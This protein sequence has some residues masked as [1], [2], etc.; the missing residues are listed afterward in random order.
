MDDPM[1]PLPTRHI[2][3]G[4]PPTPRGQDRGEPGQYRTDYEP[5]TPYTPIGPARGPA[6]VPFSARSTPAPFAGASAYRTPPGHERGKSVDPRTAKMQADVFKRRLHAWAATYFREAT[7]EIS[8]YYKPDL[9][10]LG[11]DFVG[12]VKLI[13]GRVRD[14]RTALRREAGYYDRLVM[15]YRALRHL[16]RFMTNT[17]FVSQIDRDEIV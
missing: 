5:Y 1:T 7:D 12:V 15:H 10:A 16:Y 8:L 3:T 13:D 17:E 9:L 14:K 4:R 2:M 11:P 6:R